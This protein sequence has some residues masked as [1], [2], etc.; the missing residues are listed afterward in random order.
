M[1]NKYV[2]QAEITRKEY[3]ALQELS[4][5]TVLMDYISMVIKDHIAAQ[6]SAQRTAGTCPHGIPTT[7]MCP[8]CG[9]QWP[10]Q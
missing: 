8:Q 4:N 10:E 1:R 2:V 7:S 5:G 6:H 3:L 9:D